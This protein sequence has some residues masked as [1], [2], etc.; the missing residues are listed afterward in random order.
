MKDKRKCYPIF[1]RFKRPIEVEVFTC[2]GN[3]QR[4]GFYT[5]NIFLFLSYFE[6]VNQTSLKY[7]LKDIQDDY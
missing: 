5:S 2:F 1:L 7:V 4:Y 6:I 3:L